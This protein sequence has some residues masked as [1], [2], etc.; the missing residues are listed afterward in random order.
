[1][2][3]ILKTD[4]KKLCKCLGEEGYIYDKKHITKFT[5]LGTASCNPEDKFNSGFGMELAKARCEL[6][7]AKKKVNWLINLSKDVCADPKKEQSNKAYKYYDK[8][9]RRALNARKELDNLITKING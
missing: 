5:A 3:Y 8:I 6:K 4:N 9:I 2:N 7:I 1:M